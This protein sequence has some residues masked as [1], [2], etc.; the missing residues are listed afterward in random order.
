MLRDFISISLTAGRGKYMNILL[1]YYRYSPHTNGP[2]TYID[3]LSKSL[4]GEGHS[5]DLMSHDTRW[6][7]IQVADQQPADKHRLKY[8]LIHRLQT[9]YT[10]KYPLWIY[11]R[12]M[13]RYSLEQAVKQFDLKKYDL[14]HCHDL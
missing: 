5:V 14:I 11:W 13:E 6:L 12:E 7:N 10:E 2:S 9:A 1:A 4:E 8:E 3:I